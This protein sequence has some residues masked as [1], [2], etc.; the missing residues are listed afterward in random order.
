[1]IAAL[2]LVSLATAGPV[3]G[4]GPAEAARRA[5]ATELN[6]ART[7]AGSRPL[8]PHPLLCQLARERALE[9]AASGELTVERGYLEETTRRLYRGGYKPHFWTDGSLV[10]TSLS[11]VLEQLRPIRPQ[12]VAEAIANDFDHLGVATATLDG[13]PVVTFMLALHKCT[14]D[15]ELATRLAAVEAIREEVLAAVNRVRREHGLEPVRLDSRLAAAAQG[16]AEDQ[17]RRSYYDHRSPEG[18]TAASRVRAAGLER[19][20]L[21]AEN[22][23]KGLFTPE[24]VVDRWMD[25]SGHRKNILQRRVTATGLGVAVGAGESD[26]FEVLWVQLFAG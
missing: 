1:V 25:S 14:V 15:R 2:L 24:E 10:G 21:V 6:Q 9:I 8:E 5:I 20:G 18:G 11:G 23:A 12:W 3:C 19:P 7:A 22:I 26:C 16:H 17:L 13:Q 4:A